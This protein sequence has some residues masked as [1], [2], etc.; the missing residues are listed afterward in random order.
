VVVVVDGVMSIPGDVNNVHKAKDHSCVT[1]RIGS[2]FRVMLIVNFD[3]G[4]SSRARES[5][6]R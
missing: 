4:E 3:S 2:G 1:S 5:R 6:M